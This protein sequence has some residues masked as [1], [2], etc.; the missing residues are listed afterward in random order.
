[1]RQEF[2]WPLGK[3]AAEGA[4]RAPSAPFAPA[5][6]VCA[7]AAP[8]LPLALEEHV[9]LINRA[10]AI[11]AFARKRAVQIVTHGHTPEADLEKPIGYLACEAKCRLDAFTEIVG[12]RYG[13]MNLPAD[14]RERCLRYVEIAGGILVA[15]WDRCQVEVP[16]NEPRR[17]ASRRRGRVA[18]ARAPGE[19]S[20]ASSTSPATRCKVMAASAGEPPLAH[21]AT[22]PAPAPATAP[23]G[24]LRKIAE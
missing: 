2:E 10:A 22:S 11:D 8:L 15:L 19:P 1:M 6:P 18:R 12:G 16:E 7:D 4:D 24:L 3:R 17:A 14:H 9:A 13:R 21:R 5:A 20:P 23:R